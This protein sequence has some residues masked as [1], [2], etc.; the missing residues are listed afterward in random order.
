M[1]TNIPKYKNKARV[2]GKAIVTMFLAETTQS[3][4]CRQM[5]LFRRPT[6]AEIHEVE[7][8]TPI[9]GAALP[10]EGDLHRHVVRFQGT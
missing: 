5:I 8:P 9:Q 7:V 4:K 6:H 1:F 10:T 3:M 2:N